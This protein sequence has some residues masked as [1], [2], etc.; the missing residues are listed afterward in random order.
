MYRD[1]SSPSN[2][3]LAERW[4]STTGQHGSNRERWAA[5]QNQQSSGA[6]SLVLIQ[7]KV[8]SLFVIDGFTFVCG[9]ELYQYVLKQVEDAGLYTCIASSQ[10]GEDG[11]NHWVHI[12]REYMCYS[13][14]YRRF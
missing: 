13:K 7:M 14:C 2:P 6:L 1:W 12:Q 4:A 3:Q 9:F 11:R 5:A 8:F 10:A